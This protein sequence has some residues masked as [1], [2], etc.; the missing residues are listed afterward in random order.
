[1]THSSCLS[2]SGQHRTFHAIFRLHPT[3]EIIP[4][5]TFII[6]LLLAGLGACSSDSTQPA[7]EPA[8]APT[9]PPASPAESTPAPA[10]APDAPP[11][12]ATPPAAKTEKAAAPKAEEKPAAKPADKPTTG[13]KLKPGLYAHFETNMGNFTAELNEK[14]APITVANFAGLASGTK[15][16]TDPRNGQK[17]KKPYYDGLTFHRIIDGFMIQGGDPLGTGAGGP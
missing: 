5:K 8:A 14:E 9:P 7:A 3:K 16:Y 1:M 10:A 6:L 2:N 13:A 15:E 12:V 4:M 11:P 17:S